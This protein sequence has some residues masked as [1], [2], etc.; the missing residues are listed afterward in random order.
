M[1]HKRSHSHVLDRDT[2]QQAIVNET[3]VYGDDLIKV[4]KRGRGIHDAKSFTIGWDC[5][6]FNEVRYLDERSFL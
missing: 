3:C 1:G 5:A 6:Y 2:P 4:G